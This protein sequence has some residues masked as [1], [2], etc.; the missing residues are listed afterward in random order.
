MSTAYPGLTVLLIII[1]VPIIPAYL[2][3]KFL[4]STAVTSGP[5]QGLQINISGAF[6]GYLVVFLTLIPIR[7]SFITGY[8]KW[9]V[10][11]RIVDDQG[12]VIQYLDPRY[13]TYSGSYMKSDQ[14]GNFTLEFVTTSDREYS[15]PDLYIHIPGFKNKDYFLGPKA[16]NYD[17][18]ENVG[19]VD[20]GLK[21]IRLGTIHLVA[22]PNY[23]EATC[24]TTTPTPAQTT[25]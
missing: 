17:Q 19:E 15:F 24:I 14:K 8:D 7:S 25:H 11:G 10:S 9:T 4:P 2:L 12:N 6:A 20:T 23:R 16:N 5:F 13:I 21:T 3:F 22:D 1:L 18:I